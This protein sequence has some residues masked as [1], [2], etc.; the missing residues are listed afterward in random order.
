[1]ISEFNFAKDKDFGK[2]CYPERNVSHK[3]KLCCKKNAKQPKFHLSNLKID[4]PFNQT[5]K[6]ALTKTADECVDA[7]PTGA[8]NFKNW[9]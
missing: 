8:L 1:M 5:I 2:L 3:L 9:G 6:E 4:M 7:C